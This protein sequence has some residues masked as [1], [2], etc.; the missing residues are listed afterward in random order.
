MKARVIILIAFVYFLRINSIA[1]NLDFDFIKNCLVYTDVELQQKLNSKNF[2]LIAKEYKNTGDVL[3]N[4]SD[5]FS[6]KGEDQSLSGGVETAVF[7]NVRRSKKSTF[8]SFSQSTSFSNFNI[9]EEEIKKSFKKEGV[10]QS[11]KYES[12]IL[13]YSNDK[14]LYYLFKEEDT[15]YI[16]VSSYPLE[17]TYFAEKQ[18]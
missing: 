13:K 11:E 15:Y 17:E 6:N 5:Y 10:F 3:I 16:I 9:L 7:Y 8:I 4:K 2:K 1:Q 18:K 14:T 12:S